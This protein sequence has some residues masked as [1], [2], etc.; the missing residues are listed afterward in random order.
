MP[1]SR[2]CGRRPTWHWVRE[3][4]LAGDEVLAN[5][6]KDTAPTL[7]FRRKRSGWSITDARP[8]L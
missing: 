3:G 4:I 2:G 8:L 6:E 7:L 5:V 1:M